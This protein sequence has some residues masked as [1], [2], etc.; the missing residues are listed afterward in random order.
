MHTRTPGAMPRDTEQDILRAGIRTRDQLVAA[1][2]YPNKSPALIRALIELAD[3]GGYPYSFVDGDLIMLPLLD[4]PTL[5]LE[6]LRAVVVGRTRPGWPWSRVLAAACAHPLADT[7]VVIDAL[8]H[9]PPTAVV[10]VAV[11]TADLLPLVVNWV[12]RELERKEITGLHHEHASP[13]QR[14]RIAAIAWTWRKSCAQNRGLHEFLLAHATSFTDEATLLA[15][16][17][18][19][20]ASPAGSDPLTT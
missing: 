12:V 19:L 5:T 2:A 15:A 4:E 11:A 7:D 17:A 18:A 9:A 1:V 14:A 10:E 13:D 8:W 3:G 20:C 16:G 6:N